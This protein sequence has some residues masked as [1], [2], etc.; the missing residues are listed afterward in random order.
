MPATLLSIRTDAVAAVIDGPATN[1]R[2]VLTDDHSPPHGRT[3]IVSRDELLEASWLTAEG[4]SEPWDPHTAAGPRI[5]AETDY[6]LTVEA[7]D[8]HQI[9]VRNRDSNLLA[10]VTP[11]GAHPT[12][13]SGRINFRNQ[14]GTARFSVAVDGIERLTFTVEVFPTK[15]S[16]DAEYRDL[17]DD[18][19]R[20]GRALAL[21]YLRATY[22]GGSAASADDT[23]RLEWL[24]LVRNEIRAL[25]H[26]FEYIAAHPH[27]ILDR[28]IR[29]QQAERIKRV[30]P[31]TIRAVARRRGT[32]PVTDVPGIGRVH[33]RLPAPTAIETL[34]TPEHRWLR[35]ELQ[36]VQRTLA[37][38]ATDLVTER[39]AVLR[40]YPNANTARIE[41]EINEV[42]ALETRSAALMKLGPMTAAG[43]PPPHGFTSLTLMGRPGYREAYRGLL[44]LRLGLL[45]TGSDLELSIKDLE[46]LYETWCFIKVATIVAT[47]TNTVLAR[48]DAFPITE[49]GIRVDLGRGAQHSIHLTK[50]GLTIMVV[51]NR[52]FDGDTGSQKPDILIDIRHNGWPPI[53]LILDAKYRVDASDDYVK[54]FRGYGPPAAAVNELHRYRDAIAIDHI[55][56]LGR[57]VVK[58]VALF[59]LTATLAGDFTSHR[60]WDALQTL[61]IGALPFLPNN[62][63]WVTHWLKTFLEQPPAAMA[64]PG[65]PFLAHSYAL[66]ARASGESD[67]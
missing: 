59:P 12:L 49:R 17:L 11:V 3:T 7:T 58:G 10:D 52:Q 8:G 25:E 29:D 31:A 53:Y 50:P 55:A 67:A 18:V 47:L 21:E 37:E 14:V 19:T 35:N 62:T 43:G 57:P 5:F 9:T 38:I 27:R 32:G 51:N 41:G 45:P 61:G 33:R 36:I 22:Q 23:T 34:D 2:G 28:T 42:R 26:A 44:T 30:T 46:R 24:V 56:G 13:L 64:D 39:A 63:G 66:T 60:L 1:P 16:Y 6:R 20:T 48:E 4:I 15:L 40:R 54:Q 65:P